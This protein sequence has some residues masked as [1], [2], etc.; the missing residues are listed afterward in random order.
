MRDLIPSPETISVTDGASLFRILQT[1]KRDDL[2]LLVGLVAD[3]DGGVVDLCSGIGGSAAPAVDAG[4]DL[5]CVDV[6]QVALDAL[7]ARWP[8]VSC[9]QWD[10]SSSG[11]PAAAA[12]PWPV[13][14]V[15]CAHNAVNEVGNL[16]TVFETAARLLKG[17]G[18]FFVETLT[19]VYDSPYVMEELTGFVDQ[20][21]RAWK[22]HTAVLPA[23]YDAGL[24]VLLL[25][26]TTGSREQPT[27]VV[28]HPL[29][30]R[31][32][33]EPEL[34]A[35]AETWGFRQIAR[36]GP[37]QLVFAAGRYEGGEP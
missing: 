31:I 3:A 13:G 29:V 7:Q 1:Q 12:P 34:F 2:D 28:V 26:A 8:Q 4:A 9:R 14:L 27:D 16:T 22:L 19:T 6:D 21:G 32:Y 33:P 37:R 11:L 17:N 20:T 18:V 10:L 23:D 25:V 30:R 15:V 36:P 35:T 24:H 5:L